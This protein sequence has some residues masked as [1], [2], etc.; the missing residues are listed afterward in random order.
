MVDNLVKPS[1]AVIENRLFK[2]K[3]E[4]GVMKTVG[5]TDIFYVPL[6]QY[7]T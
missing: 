7:V 5:M 4:D 3:S 6:V 1:A 2:Q